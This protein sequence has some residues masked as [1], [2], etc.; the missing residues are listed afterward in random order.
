MAY[1]NESERE[2]LLNDLVKK[3]FGQAKRKLRHM[4][5]D[6]RLVLFRNVQRQ[7]E[8]TTKYELPNRGVVVTLIE[9][10]QNSDD[11]PNT[12]Y[13]PDFE[14]ARVIIEPTAENRT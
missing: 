14:L 8:W 2:K 7:N 6:N 4:D 9:T 5:P 3:N 13:H 1:L 12:R 10:R 11:D